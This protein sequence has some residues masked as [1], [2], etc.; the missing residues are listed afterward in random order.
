[1]SQFRLRRKKRRLLI[2]LEDTHS[3]F[4]WSLF[5][6]KSP[7]EFAT[8][9]FFKLVTCYNGFQCVLTSFAFVLPFWSTTA[10]SNLNGDKFSSSQQKFNYH[11]SIF[12]CFSKKTSK[13]C[14][15]HFWKKNIASF[16]Q[17]YLL[18]LTF[19]GLRYIFS[20][21]QFPSFWSICK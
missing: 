8:G 21:F 4:I 12:K 20:D 16:S 14:V 3:W 19:Y 2:F 9:Y 1:M 18:K 17:L 15:Y 6:E 11:F 5:S 13:Q 7:L 10:C